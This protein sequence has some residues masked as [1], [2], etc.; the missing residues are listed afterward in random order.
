MPVPEP[1]YL[2]IPTQGRSRWGRGGD[3]GC[4][5]AVSLHSLLRDVIKD[6]ELLEEARQA[7]RGLTIGEWCS[8]TIDR[9]PEGFVQA[10]L[11]RVSRRVR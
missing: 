3:A 6:P 8:L 11:V 2:L 9:T 4:I 1:S 7:T 10:L 5:S